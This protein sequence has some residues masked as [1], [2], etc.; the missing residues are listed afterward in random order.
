MTAVIAA[1]TLFAFYSQS[2]AKKNLERAME[3]TGIPTMV[4]DTKDALIQYIKQRLLSM[5]RAIEYK[6]PEYKIKPPDKEDKDAK[7]TKENAMWKRFLYTISVLNVA[8]TIYLVGSNPLKFYLWQGPQSIILLTI[9]WYTFREQKQ[10][11]LLYDFCYWANFLCIIYPWLL[12]KSQKA[13][14]I[15]FTLANGPIAWAVLVF[16]QS[17]VFHSP[18]HMTSIFIHI[19]PMLLSYCIRW[20]GS[21]TNQQFAVCDNFPTCDD[22]TA[23][24]LMIDANM[25]FYVWWCIL[26]Y[27]WVFVI[28]HERI[29]SRGYQTLFDRV[30]KRWP[31]IL[32]I[33]KLDCIRKFVY[34]LIHFVL[35]NLSMVIAT[36]CWSHFWAHVGFILLI[37]GIASWNAAGHYNVSSIMHASFTHRR[38]KKQRASAL[39]HTGIV[40]V[41]VTNNKSNEDKNTTRH[42][43]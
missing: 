2:S 4:T 22:V 23:G 42:S 7:K 31:G 19:S 15:L 12:S 8:L 1:A 13:F 11:Y 43:A 18:P 25:K 14:Q 10:H 26:Y 34:V 21:E 37:T 20:Y 40:G 32:K 39:V 6:V 17:L 41:P 35:S 27:I 5:P 38:R 9:R 29:K 30:A 16:S 3:S 33:S 28:L 36:Y 24:Q